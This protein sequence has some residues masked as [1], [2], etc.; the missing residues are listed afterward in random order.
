MPHTPL[1]RSKSQLKFIFSLSLDPLFM[2][3]DC[4]GSFIPE[5]GKT[6]MTGAFSRHET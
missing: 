5:N 3:W 2:D 6:T 4:W 1:S